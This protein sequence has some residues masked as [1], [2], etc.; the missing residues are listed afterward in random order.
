MGSLDPTCSLC[1]TSLPRRSFGKL[2]SSSLSCQF[3][4]VLWNLIVLECTLLLLI[5]PLVQ[6]PGFRLNPSSSNPTPSPLYLHQTPIRTLHHNYLPLSISFQSSHH[7][8]CPLVSLAF[9]VV[10]SALLSPDSIPF[11]SIPSPPPHL[12]RES[13]HTSHPARPSPKTTGLSKPLA[14]PVSL[15]PSWKGKDKAPETREGD[16][17][18]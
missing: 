2:S 11:H 4:F 13:P 15:S 6:P 9:T 7:A 17:R 3:L 14:A 18:P 16:L 12:S 5:S 10:Y 1:S 8:R